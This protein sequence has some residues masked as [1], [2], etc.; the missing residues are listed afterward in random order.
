MG[1]CK[2]FYGGHMPTYKKYI[3][4]KIVKDE[5]GE[6][7]EVVDDDAIMSLYDTTANK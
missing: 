7:E 6:A 1:L 3:K 4:G 2:R 5:N